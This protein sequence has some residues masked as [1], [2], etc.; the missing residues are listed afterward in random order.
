MFDILWYITRIM[1]FSIVLIWGCAESDFTQS[2]DNTITKLIQG[3]ETSIR[4]EIG[5]LSLN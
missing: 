1:I 4:P 5:K 3:Q 2:E